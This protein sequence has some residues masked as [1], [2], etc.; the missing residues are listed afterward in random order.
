MLLRYIPGVGRV[1][2]GHR[3]RGLKTVYTADS[4]HHSSFDADI[5]LVDEC[6]QLVR[7]RHLR[8]LNRYQQARHF[9]FTASRNTRAD[10]AWRWLE[11]I[12][13]PVV[14]FM[15]NSEAEQLGLSAQVLVQWIEIN[16]E[17]MGGVN[18]IL[19]LDDPVEIKRM[20]FWRNRPRNRRIA[21]VVRTLVRE[22]Q[23]VLVLVDTVDHGLHLRRELPEATLCYAEHALQ[24][25][26]KRLA[27]IQ[28]GL[29]TSDEPSMTA[30]RREAYRLAFEGG[31]MRCAIATSIWHTG[32]SFD[33]LNALVRAEGAVSQTRNIQLPGRVCRIDQA[34]GKHVGLLLDCFD[35]FDPRLARRSHSRRLAYAKRKWI[36]HMEDGSVWYPRRRG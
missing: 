29:M 26:H 9:G 8:M 23:Q 1:G 36:Q 19:S 17:L 22:G 20:A 32:V 4:W 11:S 13:G 21:E 7:P 28:S 2:G 33:T 27:Y 12:Y 31:E 6:H 10:N 14:F 35:S 24:Q 18:P 30:D 16:S 25:P 34:T 5:V 3:E 15:D